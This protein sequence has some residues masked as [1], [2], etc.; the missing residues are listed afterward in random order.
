M[1]SESTI[2]IVD[3]DAGTAAALSEWAAKQR[4]SSA[5]FSSTDDFSKHYSPRQRG[6]LILNTEIANGSGWKLLGEL[7]RPSKSLPVVAVSQQATIC[8]AVR[9]MQQGAVA[10]VPK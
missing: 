5:V 10:F 9:A 4:A 3:D 2:F 6:C 7:K 8:S 1:T